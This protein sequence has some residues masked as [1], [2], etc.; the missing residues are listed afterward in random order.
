MQ[1]SEYS[2]R[3]CRDTYIKIKNSIEITPR[4]SMN[5]KLFSY[6]LHEARF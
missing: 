3:A 5:N 1:I 6:I 2:L 4:V